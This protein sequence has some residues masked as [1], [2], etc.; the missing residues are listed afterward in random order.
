MFKGNRAVHS[1][2]KFVIWC[3]GHFNIL[4]AKAGLYRE[5]LGLNAIFLLLQLLIATQESRLMLGT[6]LNKNKKYKKLDD[7]LFFSISAISI[8]CHWM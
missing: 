8:F 5:C 1:L 7:G 6:N 2:N 4:S 3:H